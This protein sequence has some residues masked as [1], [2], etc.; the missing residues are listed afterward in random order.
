MD[1]FRF[2][3]GSFGTALA[4]NNM[5]Y[6]KNLQFLRMNELQNVD[7]LGWF[8][9]RMQALTGMSEAAVKAAFAQY[10]TLMAYSYGFYNVFMHAAYWGLLG[11]LFVVLLFVKNPFARRK[12]V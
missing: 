6:F 11:A 1:Y 3:G 7:Y 2:V 4:T 12:N 9:D 10:E 5:E 8:L